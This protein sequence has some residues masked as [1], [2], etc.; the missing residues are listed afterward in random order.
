M[1]SKI[2]ELS[3]AK[4]LIHGDTLLS[5]LPLIISFLNG[6]KITAQDF[7]SDVQGS[8]AFVVSPENRY[9]ALQRY[10]SQIP[11]LAGEYDL[12]D[13]NIPENSIAVIPI[14]GV[15]LPWK[16]QRISNM[17]LQAN[18]N[19]KIS[20]ILFIVNSPGGVV[21]YLD[22]ASSVIKNSKIPTTA[23]ILSVAA[24]GAMWL[25]SN[26]ND[27][28]ISSEMDVVGSIGAKM[29]FMDINTFLKE[30]LNITIY[31]L[32]A[33]KSTEKENEWRQLIAGNSQPVIDSLDFVNEIFHAT[34]RENLGIAAESKVFN[35]GIFYAE[36]AISLGL[37]HRIATF[38]DA[39]D[40]AYKKGQIYSINSYNLNF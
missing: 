25:V 17:V 15:L 31:D 7:S 16:S 22:I 18:E 12:S 29:S 37:A 33:T 27:I 1:Y 38:E 20:S 2:L 39:I 10:T 34:I 21:N 32:Y 26:V 3:N 8:T 35:G 11:N 6:A 13:Q 14:Q 23:F 4:W 36:E 28:L 40:L 24:S 19:E 5:Y 30:K 9:K